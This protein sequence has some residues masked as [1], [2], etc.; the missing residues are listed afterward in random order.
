MKSERD[1]LRVAV[2]QAN[3]LAREFEKLAD[4]K[5]RLAGMESSLKANM[6]RLAAWDVAVDQQQLDGLN[7]TLLFINQRSTVQF[8]LCKQ[9][10]L[11]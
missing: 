4:M 3:A 2:N 9:P 1:R 8:E 5:S 7:R 10:P 11:Q 6:A